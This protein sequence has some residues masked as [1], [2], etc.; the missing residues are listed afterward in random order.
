MPPLCVRGAA[1]L[2]LL[3]NAG[4]DEPRIAVL[5]PGPRAVPVAYATMSAVLAALRNEEAGR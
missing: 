2:V 5:P 3:V 4:D 1:R